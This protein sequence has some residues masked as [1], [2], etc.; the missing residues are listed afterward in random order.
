M[1]TSKEYKWYEDPVY[2]AMADCPEIQEQISKLDYIPR[3][4]GYTI[5][6]GDNVF[7]DRWQASCVWLP[8]QDQLQEMYGDFQRCCMQM[9]IYWED[10]TNYEHCTSMEQLWLAF[11]MKEKHSKVWEEGKWK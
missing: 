6:S 5:Y 11:V 8:R 4:S 9:S 3:H 1:D 2:I 10:D 7:K